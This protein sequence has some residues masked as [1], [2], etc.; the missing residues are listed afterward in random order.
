MDGAGGDTD[1]DDAHRTVAPVAV[2]LVVVVRMDGRVNAWLTRNIVIIIN[3]FRTK[4]VGAEKRIAS[5]NQTGGR[6]KENNKY[7]CHRLV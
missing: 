6:R 2:V 1:E 5:N 3:M 7:V 4:L